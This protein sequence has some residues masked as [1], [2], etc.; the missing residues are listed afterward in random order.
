MAISLKKLK[1]ILPQWIIDDPH[2][3]EVMRS[4]AGYYIGTRT[5]DYMPFARYTHYMSEEEAKELL[6]TGDWEHIARQSP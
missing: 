2:E 3:P 5:E 4:G 1:T 6:K